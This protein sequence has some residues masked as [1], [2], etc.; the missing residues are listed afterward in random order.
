MLQSGIT[1][2]GERVSGSFAQIRI[3]NSSDLFAGHLHPQKTPISP[4]VLYNS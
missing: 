3:M 2:L 1:H 4:W